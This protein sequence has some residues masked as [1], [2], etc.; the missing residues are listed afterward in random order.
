MTVS[1]EERFKS[2]GTKQNDAINNAWTMWYAGFFT[3]S[4]K[5]TRPGSTEQQT[6]SNV[7]F[8]HKTNG[9]YADCSF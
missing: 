6:F 7:S 3:R 5:R 1:V 9:S 2:A 8:I 4:N